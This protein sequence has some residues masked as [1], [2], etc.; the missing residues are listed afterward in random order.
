MQQ[1]AYETL[2]S[3]NL[4]AQRLWARLYPQACSGENPPQPIAVMAE[5]QTAG[6]GRLGR[7]WV[8]PPGGLWLSLVWPLGKPLGEYQGL[9]LIA[10]L[11]TATAIAET[12]GL[13]CQIKWPN[14]V[15]LSQRKLAGILCQAEPGLVNPA[16]VIGIGI[17][18]N[19]NARSLGPNLRQPPTSLLDELGQAV[20]LRLL[21]DA[22]LKQLELRLAEYE[23]NGIGAYVAEIRERLAW[24]GENVQCTDSAGHVLASGKLTGVDELGRV[25]IETKSGM[26]SLAIGELRLARVD[27]SKC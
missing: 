8:S 18:G 9:P 26:E 24:L 5:M 10:G 3:T 19:F 4:E 25:F 6:M 13:E 11:A 21:R 2:D 1:Y 17:N 14:D 20:D 27:C 7:T 22:L 12:V 16:I 15:L 23:R